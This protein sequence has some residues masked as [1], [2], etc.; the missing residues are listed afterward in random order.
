M[1]R[2]K[3]KKT[4][5]VYEHSGQPRARERFFQLGDVCTFW[6]VYFPPTA[7]GLSVPFLFVRSSR[8]DLELLVVRYI[9]E[10]HAIIIYSLYPG[11]VQRCR[12][13]KKNITSMDF[14]LLALADIIVAF[15]LVISNI[16]WSSPG[17]PTIYQH[18]QSVR[19]IYI[20]DRFTLW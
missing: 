1:L 7:C 10:T 16:Y 6:K 15:E 19:T 14:A 8:W 3:I 2:C 13:Q 5:L 4:V 18:R 20:E 11:S 9:Y 12:L 17:P